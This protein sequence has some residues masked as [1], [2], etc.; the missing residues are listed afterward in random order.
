MTEQKKEDSDK[1][2]K[3]TKKS[4]QPKNILDKLFGG[5]NL[6]WPKLIIFAIVIGVLV[7]II[8][9]IPAIENTPLTDI[10]AIMYW[11]VLFGVII[12][13]NSKSN[14]DSAL[15]C[16][17]FFL[18]SQPLIYL[19]E[20]PFKEMGWGL[21]GYWRQTWAWWTLAT[22]PMGYIGY[23]I[24]K[25]KI[26]S[27]FILAPALVLVALEGASGFTEK[28]SILRSIFCAVILI[29]LL[30]GALKSWKLRGISVV[31]AIVVAFAVYFIDAP[32][33]EDYHFSLSYDMDEY[34]VT[35][36]KEWTVESDLGDHLEL[37]QEP[38]YDEDGNE[39]EEKMYYLVFQGTGNDFG[40]HE[41]TFTSGEEVKH[42]QLSI[43][44]D[45]R[46]HTNE[47]NCKE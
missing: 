27:A 12:I 22:I 6:T 18:I 34:G 17:I 45:G 7:G 41:V 14:V 37:R 26:Y 43:T 15:K 40:E 4:E 30:L 32:K 31:A 1:K 3:K 10:G 11:W 13:M 8:M 28:D 23:W 2:E 9:C 20:V 19:V 35:T 33:P 29:A 5:I 24:K 38:I 21:F 25:Q 16:F 44:K 46:S 39:T 47:L 42:C 36:E